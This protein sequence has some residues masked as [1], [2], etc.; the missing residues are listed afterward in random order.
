[1]RRENACLKKQSNEVD[2]EHTTVV[3]TGKIL[4]SIMKSE[5]IRVTN[6]HGARDIVKLRRNNIDFAC[7]RAKLGTTSP[8]NV[9]WMPVSE[10]SVFDSF[11]TLIRSVC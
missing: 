10:L 3:I 11:D 1:M 4:N 8:F 9:S 2:D 7:W 5:T 6:D